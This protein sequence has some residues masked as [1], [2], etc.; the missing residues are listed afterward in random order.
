MQTNNVTQAIWTE[1]QNTGECNDFNGDYNVLASW[2]HC[3]RQGIDSY[4]GGQPTYLE[5]DELT[6]R[7]ENNHS[8]ISIAQ[9]IL[10]EAYRLAA[11]YKLVVSLLDAD[12]YIL[13]STGDAEDVY[14]QTGVNYVPGMCCVEDVMGTSSF[15]LVMQGGIPV[16][17]AGPEHYC[18][19]YHHVACAAAPI[20][21]NDD[22]IIGVVT[23]TEIE[24]EASYCSL[25]IVGVAAKAIEAGI[26]MQLAQEQI[27]LSN[28]LKMMIVESISDGLL[29]IDAKGIV[30]H[31]NAT[32]AKILGVTVMES[33]G[34]HISEVVD[35]K[36]V[37]LQVL[38]TG[39]GYIDKEFR[40]ESKRGVLHFVK[41]AI[42]LRDDNGQLIGVMDVF[43]EIKRVRKMVN[44]MVGAQ[45]VFTLDDIMGESDPVVEMRRLARLAAASETTILLE[46]ESGTGKELLAQAIHNCSYHRE[47]PFIAINCGAI[48]RDLIE[49][50]LFGYE[51]GAFTG[52]KHGGRPGKFEMAQGGTL[53]LDEVGEMPFEMQVKLLRVLQRTQVVRV[54]GSQVIPV[55]V[56]II[57][58]TNRN[59]WQMVQDGAFR[60]DLYYRLNVMDILLPPLR[61]RGDDVLLLI[62]HFL[63]KFSKTAGI[64]KKIAPEA[65]NLL[66][67]WNWPGNV[68]ELENA[69]EHAC[70]L[71]C[72][73]D[74]GIEH[75]PRIIQS[76]GLTKKAAPQV[77]SLKQAERLAIENVIQI[78][79]G[80]VSQSAR[81][82][83]VGRNTLYEKLKEYAIEYKF[84]PEKCS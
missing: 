53:F 72:G 37:V 66:Q 78:T 82:L 6:K 61:D 35:F 39:K 17:V 54:G 27:T 38:E 25:G 56:R 77:M 19:R 46:G 80:N 11:H 13:I 81:L 34:R 2:Q 55:D 50:E 74:I 3:R 15:S 4:A 70:C 43:R 75:L 71:S 47:G 26:R 59:L 40:L 33:I 32:G 14:R 20:K 44:Q 21:N 58:A 64:S 52:A 83:G 18:L 63:N 76:C 10:S 67:Q 79:K 48:P 84:S 24:W 45:A 62:H 31:I 73:G 30:T 8:L 1:F 9:P 5:K 16:R 41:T 28:R 51:E 65:L 7:L 22:T 60:E 57:V 42:P 49:S 29:T 36:P 12:G 69:I 68:R 23:L